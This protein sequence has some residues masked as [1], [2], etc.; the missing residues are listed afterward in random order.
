MDP[1]QSDRN[2]SLMRE[3]MTDSTC[4]KCKGPQDRGAVVGAYCDNDEFHDGGYQRMPPEPRH[5]VSCTQYT[6]GVCNCGVVKH[7]PPLIP[8]EGARVQPG[9]CSKCGR[10]FGVYLAPGEAP[11]TECERCQ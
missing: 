6:L 1:V 10:T 2:R 9:R 3:M 5:A 4:P 11:P 8:P 7:D